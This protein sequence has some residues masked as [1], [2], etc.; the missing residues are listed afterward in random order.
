[1]FSPPRVALFCRAEPGLGFP[2]AGALLFFRAEVKVNYRLSFAAQRRRSEVRS[3][4]GAE[5]A[6]RG[7]FAVVLRA[8]SLLWPA[9][10]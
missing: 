7:S 3:A 5:Q 9:K 6:I 4:S 10:L 2:V 1:M 8:P